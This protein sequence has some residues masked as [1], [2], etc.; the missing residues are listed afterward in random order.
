[1]GDGYREQDGA[2]GGMELF[3]FATLPFAPGKD[4]PACGDGRRGWRGGGGGGEVER[5]LLPEKEPSPALGSIV[6][7]QSSPLFPLSPFPLVSGLF[8]SSS[9][10]RKIWFLLAKI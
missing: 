3:F 7:P 4:E 9:V 5:K 1:M 8:S 6:L 10:R 2:A